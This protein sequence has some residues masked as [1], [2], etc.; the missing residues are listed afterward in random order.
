MLEKFVSNVAKQQ[1]EMVDLKLKRPALSLSLLTD[2]VYVSL[3][4]LFLSMGCKYSLYLISQVFYHYEGDK[5]AHNYR[6]HSDMSTHNWNNY[7]VVDKQGE[8]KFK[9]LLGEES[10]V[11][12]GWDINWLLNM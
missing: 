2:I 11:E 5:H 6:W 4:F 8:I 10:Y 9:K 7:W 3:F 12:F 1:L